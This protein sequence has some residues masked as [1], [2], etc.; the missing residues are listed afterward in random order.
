MLFLG[1]NMRPSKFVCGRRDLFTT[2]PGPD[3]GGSNPGKEGCDQMPEKS[4]IDAAPCA[5]LP[6]GAGGDTCA[7]AAVAAAAAIA[8]GT[9]R[10]MKPRCPIMLPSCSCLAG[11]HAGS[12]QR[13]GYP[14]A[15][16]GAPV[17][18]GGGRRRNVVARMK[19]PARQSRA[20][21]QSGVVGVVPASR[22]PAQGPPPS[23]TVLVGKPTQRRD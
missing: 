6:G 11:A 5:P 2:G 17:E 8:A 1:G 23:G 12:A 3:A 16:N 18:M 7:K 21:A 9:T 22:Q 14:K 15:G 10:K 19:H 20:V 4:G 13:I